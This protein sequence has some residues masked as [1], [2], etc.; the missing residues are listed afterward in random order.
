MAKT[1]TPKGNTEKVILPDGSSVWFNS[2]S[3]LIYIIFFKGNERRVTLE[4]ERYFEV[5]KDKSKPFI[6]LTK[7]YENTCSRY[8][9]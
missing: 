2:G 7:K 3:K 5:V 9:F 4:G 6:V 1:V 8:F